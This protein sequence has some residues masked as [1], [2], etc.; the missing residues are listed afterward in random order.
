MAQIDFLQPDGLLRNAGFSQA[1]VASG[2]RVVYTS[3]QVAVDEQGSLV[4]GDDLA[5]Q[6]TQ[7][8]RNLGLALQAAGATFSD[9][10]KLTTYVVNYRP[11]QRTVIA[12]A[13][14]PFFENRP[15]PASALV[16]V[17]TLALP[18][19]LVEVEAVAVTG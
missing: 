7:A 6:L 9:V 14:A 12:A 8:M 4:G 5:A 15:R 10:V 17:A 18:E 2:T 13:R 11:E 3:G 16:G 19:W 1:V